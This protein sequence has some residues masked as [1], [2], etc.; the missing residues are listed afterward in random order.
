VLN[1]ESFNDFRSLFEQRK[2]ERELFAFLLF[3]ERQSQKALQKYAVEHFEWLNS[4]AIEAKIFFFAFEPISIKGRS[5]NPS[6]RVAKL[7]GLEREK[8]PGIVVFTMLDT[9]ESASKF[10]YFPLDSALF[11]KEQSDIE[12]VLADFFV[13]LK[14]ANTQGLKSDELLEEV[15]RRISAIQRADRLRPLKRYFVVLGKAVVAAPVNFPAQVG[16]AFANA[17]ARASMGA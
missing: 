4:L 10:V 14:F 9:R 16:K 3:D 8:L 15:S 7:F 6:S 5:I 12:D 2:H 13:E 17:M 11:K 1:V